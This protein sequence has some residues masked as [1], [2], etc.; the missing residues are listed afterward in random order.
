[1]VPLVSDVPVPVALVPVEP[2]A[3]VVGPVVLLPV[4]SPVDWDPV[5]LESPVVGP[6]VPDPWPDELPDE[7]DE[8]SSVLADV[9]GELLQAASPRTSTAMEQRLT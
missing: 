4:R 7:P 1:M 2:V 5:A 3:E 6:V 8:V 9:A